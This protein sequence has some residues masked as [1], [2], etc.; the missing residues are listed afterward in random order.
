MNLLLRRT[1]GVPQMIKRW[2]PLQ[3]KGY[4]LIL[5]PNYLEYWDGVAWQPAPMFDNQYDLIFP[6]IEFTCGGTI[7]TLNEYSWEVLNEAYWIYIDVLAI[8]GY[9]GG[10]CIA[11][12]AGYMP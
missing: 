2:D 12:A 3:T 6:V 11:N 1:P 8:P 5:N 4:S 9:I 7:I 10:G